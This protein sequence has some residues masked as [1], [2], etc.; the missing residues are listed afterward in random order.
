MDIGSDEMVG[1]LELVPAGYI[2]A[3][4]GGGFR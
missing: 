3:Y 4:T 2:P 1:P